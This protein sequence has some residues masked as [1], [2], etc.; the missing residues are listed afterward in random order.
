LDERLDR[1]VAG[2]ATSRKHGAMS[3]DSSAEQTVI[4]EVSAHLIPRFGGLA[5][6]EVTEVVRGAHQELAGQPVQ[7]FV[8]VL[9]ENMSR[10]RLRAR[11]SHR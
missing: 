11:F 6:A 7:T 9:V 2:G 5:P 8:P 1:A 4:E 3:I 10:N